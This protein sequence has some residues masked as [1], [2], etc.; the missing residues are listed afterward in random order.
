[1][2]VVVETLPG[3]VFLIL[4]DG[5]ERVGQ[6]EVVVGPTEPRYIVQR[7]W[8]T[9][10]RRSDDAFA[11]EAY[12][13]LIAKAIEMGWVTEEEAARYEFTPEGSILAGS[14]LINLGDS[15]EQG[16]D[17]TLAFRLEAYGVLEATGLA[18]GAE[19]S[20][21]NDAA[22][23]IELVAAGLTKEQIVELAGPLEPQPI[24]SPDVPSS[25]SKPAHLLSN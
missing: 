2:N 10:T 6:V 23:L 17:D 7:L 11:A 4:M 12:P 18:I 22:A 15:P 19:L 25:P 16:M 5:D 3:V 14:V 8:V 21:P 1:M 24:R 9:P 13:M 20:M